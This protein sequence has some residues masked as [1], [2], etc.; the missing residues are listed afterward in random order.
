MGTGLR[1]VGDDVFGVVGIK[2]TAVAYR[3]EASFPWRA[4]RKV[5][6]MSVLRGLLAMASIAGAGEAIQAIFRKEKALA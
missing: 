4:A 1:Y 5:V 2:R 3:G 6:R